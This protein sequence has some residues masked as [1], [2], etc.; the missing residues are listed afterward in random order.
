MMNRRGAL[1]LEEMERIRSATEFN[2]SHGGQKSR[3]TVPN[4][5]WF[6]QQRTMEFNRSHG[7]R[8]SR[9]TAPNVR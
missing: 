9:C 4:D 7:G 5:L 8:R 3:C 6:C 2:Q 1:M